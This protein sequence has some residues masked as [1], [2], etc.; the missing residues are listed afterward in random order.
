MFYLVDLLRTLTWE[1][2]SQIALRDFSE[3]VKEGSGC[4]GVF[5]IITK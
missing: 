4:L 3:E 1:A 2:D 5:E